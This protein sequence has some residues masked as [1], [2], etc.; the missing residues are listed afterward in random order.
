VKLVVIGDQDTVWGFA[1]AGVGGQIVATPQEAQ[2]ALDA[3]LA[4]AEVG[5]VL[6]TE[7]VAA[8]TGGRVDT[9]M[10]RSARP[11]VIV[12]PG[13]GGPRPDRPTLSELIR[14]TIGVRM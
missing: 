5:I 1:L 12:I 10:V 9:L 8:M 7:D 3:A 14:Q 2:R 13:P 11:L 6:V 4:D